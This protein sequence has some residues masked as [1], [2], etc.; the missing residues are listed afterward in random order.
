MFTEKQIDAARAAFSYLRDNMRSEWGDAIPKNCQYVDNEGRCC[1]V[2]MLMRP[3]FIEWI[4]SNLGL[5]TASVYSLVMY[6]GYKKT[7]FL[8]PEFQDIPLKFL[9]GLQYRF[10]ERHATMEDKMK[11]MEL[12]FKSRER[13]CFGQVDHD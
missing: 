7:A 10:D 11:T 3:E 8:R 9:A 2:G 4:K 13:I 6:E 12:F 5:N 1:A